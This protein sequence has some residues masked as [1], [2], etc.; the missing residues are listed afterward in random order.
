MQTES[1]SSLTIPAS[2]VVR[3]GDKSL[4]WRVRDNKLQKVM[5]DVTQRD[6]RTGDYVLKAGLAEGDQV[7]RHPSAMLKEDQAVQASAPAKSSM[8]RAQEAK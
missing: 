2:A 4:A 7:I 6:A 5:L 3:D 1:K 8:A